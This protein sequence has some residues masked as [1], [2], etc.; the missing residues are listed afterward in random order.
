MF[1]FHYH[2]KSSPK[3]SGWSTP[4]KFLSFSF[5]FR[6]RNVSTKI[7]RQARCIRRTRLRSTDFSFELQMTVRNWMNMD[8]SA[9]RFRPITVNFHRKELERYER[10]ESLQESFFIQGF[11]VRHRCCTVAYF[12][13]DFLR[14]VWSEELPPDRVL[15]ESLTWVAE[16]MWVVLYK[17]NLLSKR[18]RHLFLYVAVNV[19]N[20]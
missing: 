2:Q 10:S 3:F 11:T 9:L 6:R 7:E 18:Y 4:Q 13:V 16:N 12:L 14:H 1:D 5:L 8:F 15:N 20:V 19:F 17:E